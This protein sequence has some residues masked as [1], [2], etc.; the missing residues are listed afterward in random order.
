M[1]RLLTVIFA[2]I[3]SL[4]AAGQNSR[5]G[6]QI[7]IRLI[8][9]DVVVTD[10][11]GKRVYG[12]AADDFELFEGRSR[13]EI[14]N[15]AE[16][17]RD[18][19]T[20]ESPRAT[21]VSSRPGN[22][23]ILMD[24]LPREKFVRSTTFKH[25]EQV[26]STLVA[27]G[28]RVGLVFWEPGFDRWSTIAEM[29]ADAESLR[30]AVS[31]L[32]G[33]VRAER[34]PTATADDAAVTDQFFE[35]AAAA[36]SGFGKSIDVEAHKQTTSRFGGESE[37]FKFRRK[38]SAMRRLVGSFG[39]QP[40]RK[41]LVYV[42]NNFKLPEEPGARLSARGM[43]EDLAKAAN[44]ARV[45]FYAARPHV[46]D[47]FEEGGGFELQRH[48]EALREL[49]GPTGGTLDFGLPSMATI[50]AGVVEDLESYYSLAYRARSDGRDRERRI[51]VKA[52]NRDYRVRSRRSVVEKSDETLARDTLLARLFSEEGGGD[53]SFDV[54]VGEPR[55]TGKDRWL[56]PVVLRIPGR[57][58]QFATERNENVARLKI[59]FVA[60]NGVAEVTK[61]TED[62]LRIAYGKDAGDGFVQYSVQILSNSR[63][64]VISLGVFD[65][66]TGLFGVRTIDTR[67]TFK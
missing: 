23:L 63:G 48:L 21:A 22:V 65:R 39:A 37:L 57:Q 40:G 8:E 34:P 1:A 50:G 49:T 51:R 15:S 55:R 42:S 59:L 29:T 54:T 43:V 26:V 46:P 36:G 53:L 67:S 61:V 64:S 9:I 52:K 38:T 12:L 32:A 13:Q 44:A 28:N 17:R 24:L 10:A 66:R 14:T 56:L 41:S 11:Q 45:T 35:D 6:E 18:R 19:A 16:Y 7:E 27:G 62:D 33:T 5:F 3:L 2:W 20:S 25:L 30:R 58:L 47:P 60:G 31:R 4:P